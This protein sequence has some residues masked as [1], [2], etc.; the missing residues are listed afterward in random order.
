MAEPWRGEPDEVEEPET[1]DEAPLPDGV[2]PLRGAPQKGPGGC[3]LTGCLYTTVIL[4]AVAL[5]L[6]VI[7]ALTRIWITSPMPRM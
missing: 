2:V 3:G 6:M 7:A 5:L 4:F 1:G